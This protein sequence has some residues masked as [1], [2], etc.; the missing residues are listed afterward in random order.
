[1]SAVRGREL[2]RVWRV[3][4]LRVYS[5]PQMW[6]SFF[7]D[8][9]LHVRH[10]SVV[11]FAKYSTRKLWINLTVLG[12]F[13]WMWKTTVSLIMSVCP[14]VWVEQLGSHWTDLYEIWYLRIFKKFVEKI[15]V[16]LKSNTNSLLLYM[17]TQHAFMIVSRSVLLRVRNVS[18]KVLEKIKTYIWHSITFFFPES[19]AVYETIW[20]SYG[21]VRQHR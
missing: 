10:K 17:K 20:K 15:Q 16:S 21:I 1:M 13:A 18:D 5:E 19:R 4:S 8:I 14:S 7:V 12:S 6:S 11:F 9:C 2:S 3:S